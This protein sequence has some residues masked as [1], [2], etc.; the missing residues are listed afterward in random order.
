MKDLP[1]MGGSD[2]ELKVFEMQRLK[3]EQDK[4]RKQL[5]EGDLELTI[6]RILK[7]PLIYLRFA[8]FSEN[9]AR[10]IYYS[11]IGVGGY[12]AYKKFKK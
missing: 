1:R 3:Y 4:V 7:A 8:G 5:Q 2:T 11:L 12:F 10:I 9:Q 6:R